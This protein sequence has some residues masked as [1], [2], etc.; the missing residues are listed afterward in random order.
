MIPSSK[1][2]NGGSAR[3]TRLIIAVL[4]AVALLF[5]MLALATVKDKIDA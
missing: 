3:Q 1:A 5:F 2:L 4:G